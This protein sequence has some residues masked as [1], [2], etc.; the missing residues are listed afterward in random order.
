[1]LRE[2]HGCYFIMEDY[3]VLAKIINDYPDA[4]SDRK[5]L[6]ALFLDFFPQDKLK[7]NTLM[8]VFDDGIVD[9]MQKMTE[10]DK[11]ARHR[12]V[13]S[14]V[15]GY[16]IKTENAENAVGTWAE[17]LGLSPDSHQNSNAVDDLVVEVQWVNAD[18]NNLYEYEETSRGIKI[19]KFVDFDEPVVTIP[20]MIEGKKVLEIGNY[21]FKGCVG[22]EKVII[23]DGIEILGNGV[24]LNCKELKEVI[25][26]KTL[27]RIG[28]MDPTGCPKILGSLTKYEGA[29]EY[30]GL[31][32]IDI[33][34][35]VKVIGENTFSSCMRLKVVY[36]PDRLKEIK[37]NTF[38]WC[39]SLKEVKMPDELVIIR[40]AAFTGC[41]SLKSVV[42]P[43]GVKSI[44]QG[45][46]AGCKSLES[47]YIPNSV[48]EIGGGKSSGY[49][50][51]FGQ[52]D[53]RHKDFTILCNAGSYAMQYA[54]AQQIRCAK[55]QD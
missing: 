16:G 26:P 25:L 29:F 2:R 42:L 6:H 9:E 17:S 8:M 15:Q 41:E 43:E 40:M 28:T 47:I 27:K 23:S 31:E 52:V 44:E 36:L 35:S 48:G 24:F 53:E 37:E 55:A 14:L 33:P 5:K 12:F 3:I 11:I 49:L 30:S 22:I 46:F 10:M 39:K 45:A 20:N 51:T 50:Q 34:N 1:M 7:R 32:S 13:K 4:L 18:G 54:R 19:Q 38:C 21:A